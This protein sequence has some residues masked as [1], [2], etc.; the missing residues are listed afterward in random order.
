MKLQKY[1][2]RLCEVKTPKGSGLILMEAETDDEI[3]KADYIKLTKIQGK[4]LI[5]YYRQA[6]KSDTNCT[7]E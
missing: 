6:E 4:A 1:L 2:D 3:S 5:E 7:E